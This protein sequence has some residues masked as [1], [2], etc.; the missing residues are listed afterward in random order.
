MNFDEQLTRLLMTNLASIQFLHIWTY[1]VSTTPIR[2]IIRNDRYVR[3]CWYD[4]PTRPTNHNFLVVCIA[5][6]C[7]LYLIKLFS[8][9]SLLSSYQLYLHCCLILTPCVICI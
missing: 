9:F 5:Q 4:T 1:V 6:S 7:Y 3:G 8:Q 2:T